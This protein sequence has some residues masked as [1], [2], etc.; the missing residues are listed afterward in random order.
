ML[1]DVC[2][3]VYVLHDGFIC[4]SVLIVIL[5]SPLSPANGFLQKTKTLF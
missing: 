3:N 5:F 1:G 2:S 4:A